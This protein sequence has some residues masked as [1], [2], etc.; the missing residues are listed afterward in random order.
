LPGCADTQPGKLDPKKI[1]YSRLCS[2]RG[3]LRGNVLLGQ[4]RR[5][6]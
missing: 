6:G 4:K 5:E 2:K 3:R 1:G